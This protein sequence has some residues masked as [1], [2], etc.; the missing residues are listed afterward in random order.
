MIDIPIEVLILVENNE[1]FPN[2]EPH[3]NYVG[4]KNGWL[5]FTIDQYNIV[6]VNL[7]HGAWEDFRK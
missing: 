5:L 7:Y 2:L 6:T 4:D 3:K 1:K